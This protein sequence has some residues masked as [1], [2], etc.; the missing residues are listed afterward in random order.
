MFEVQEKFLVLHFGHRK[1]K[2]DCYG[3]LSSLQQIDWVIGDLNCLLIAIPTLKVVQATGA[4][5]G[6][7][8]LFD[9]VLDDLA[10]GST[11]S[12]GAVK[13]LF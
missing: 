10:S 7:E 6:Q 5:L 4:E 2:V 9:S 11:L 12:P 1:G 8:S 3:L 13:G